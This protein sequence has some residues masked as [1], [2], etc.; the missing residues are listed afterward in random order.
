MAEISIKDWLVNFNRG[1]YDSKSHFV[2]I[3][4]GWYDWF[5]KDSSL[6]SKT[7][8]L[9]KKLASLVGSPKFDIEKTYVWFKNNCPFIGPLYDDFRI[10]D[11]ETGNTRYTVAYMPKGSHGC[12]DAHW[13][14]YGIDNGFK[15]PIVEGDWKAVKEWFFE[16]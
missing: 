6:A 13:E 12:Q 11:L 14:L 2:Q 4:A 10:A 9:G 5:C 8:K 15:E 3:E 7:K 16:K 1:A